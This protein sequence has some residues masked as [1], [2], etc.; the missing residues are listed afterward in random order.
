MNGAVPTEQPIRVEI[1]VR[2]GIPVSW[3]AKKRN[4]ALIGHLRPT[5]KPDWDN[6]AKL[7]D[8]CNGIVF[9]DDKQIVDGM[10]RKVYSEHPGLL[11]IIEPVEPPVLPKHRPAEIENAPALP[12]DLFGPLAL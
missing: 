7:L 12:R 4:A 5:V 9:T 2:Y 10:V 3:S 11:A 8:A 6:A 1:E